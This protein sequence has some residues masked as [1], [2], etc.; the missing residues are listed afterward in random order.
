MRGWQGKLLELNLSTRKAARTELPLDVYRKFL[1]GTGL[2]SHVLFEGIHQNA[3]PLGPENVLGVFTGPL[4]GTRF[5]GA[6]RVEI[7]SR[8]PLTG[9]WGE[10]SMGGFLGAALKRAGW[11]GAVFLGSAS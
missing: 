8:S 9:G 7:C 4:T 1:G 2:A 10:A 11:D 3:D 5:P 6:G